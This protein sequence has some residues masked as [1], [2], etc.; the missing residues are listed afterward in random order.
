MIRIVPLTVGIWLAA[1]I[2]FAEDLSVL[3]ASVNGVE[4]Q[5]MVYQHLLRRAREMLD[6]RLAE[7]A[8][9]KTAD[10]VAVYQRKRK[11]FFLEKIGVLP[12][13]TPINPRVTGTIERD[14]YRIEKVIFESRPR[15]YVTAYFYLPK[16]RPPFPGVL[17]PC[18]HTDN[19]KLG[20]SYQAACILLAKQ[21]M[22]V[23]CF[24]PIEQGERYQ[25]FN[26]DG[27]RR[28]TPVMN[29]SLVG[30]GST[31]VGRNAAQFEIWDGMRAIDYL[32][33]RPE[34]DPE[35]IGCT[36]NSGGGTQT[37][38]LMALDDRITC[39][40]PSCYLTNF[41]WLLQTFGPPDAEQ[42]I[43]AQIAFG[44]DHPDYVIMRAPKPTRMLLALHDNC[45]DIRGAQEN[46][47][48]GKRIF[49]LLG[50]PDQL[51]VVEADAPHG[52]SPTL[53]IGAVEWMQQWLLRQDRPV[54]ELPYYGHHYVRKE[55]ASCTLEGQVMRLPGA[56]ST[57]DFNAESETQLAQDR[58][59]RWQT[60]DR[61][62]MQTEVRR[63]AAIEKLTEL[64]EPEVE[65]V[66]TIERDG[67]RI[68]K[69]IFRP[70]PDLW[71]PALAFVPQEPSGEACLYLHFVGKHY[72]AAPHGPIVKRVKQGQVVL[73]FDLPDLGETKAGRGTKYIRRA[74]FPYL[75]G[76]SMVAM[77]AREILRCAR[78]L[79]GFESPGGPRPVHLAAIG[80]GVGPA[81]M[82]AAALEPQLFASYTFEACPLSWTGLVHS[83]LPQ[84]HYMGNHW[85]ACI[86]H[87]A[88]QTYDLTDLLAC[89]PKEKV[90]ILKPVDCWNR[91][92]TTNLGQ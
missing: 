20:G 69:L 90:T 31:L 2:G 89:L 38:Y 34:V 72:H 5:D 56:R 74:Y 41:W 30:L 81:A 86:V 54:T 7:Q 13:R 88:L 68:D 49:T 37:A 60:T 66:G 6:R 91:P 64:A 17:V 50:K 87:G 10:D 40:A 57:Y 65:K 92:V 25:L 1:A 80:Y 59:R 35:R 44:M 28:G 46:Y 3:P 71:L 85:I 45:A 26:G 83:K 21:G 18:G 16:G 79:R 51:T 77:R 47:R 43:H 48:Q 12:E 36:G 15:H 82:H 76:E 27:T 58:K 63:I 19:G 14:D 24:D 78:F 53:R 70:A 62:S 9:L 55:E 52:F 42:L 8:E 75:L 23:L 22:A 84:G 33:S 11:L 67:Y 32:Q 4:P 39:A 29:H 73:A 61:G